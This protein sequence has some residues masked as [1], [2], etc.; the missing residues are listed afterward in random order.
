MR[1]HFLSITMLLLSA[2]PLYAQKTLPLLEDANAWNL[3]ET[4]PNIISITDGELTVKRR[5]YQSA[6]IM[7]TAEHENFRLEFDF[8]VHRWCELILALHAPWN[9]AWPAGLEVVLSDHAGRA[10]SPFGAGALLGNVAPTSVPVRRNDQWNHCEITLDWPTF[11]LTINGEVVQDLDLSADE[12]LRYKLRKGR[13][14]FRD[15][16][17]WGFNVRNMNLTPLPDTQG[18]LTLFDGTS[19]EGWKEVRPGDATWSLK[20]GI[21]IGDNG[22]GY[23]QHERAVQDFDLQL[24]YRSTPTANGGV[25]FRWM[26]DDSDR[27][28]EIQI[29]DVP[30][31]T[32]PSASIYSISRARGDAQF[33]VG[34]WQLLQ[35]SVR[36][37]FAVTHLNGVQTAIT[38]RLTKIRSGHI[39]LQMHKEKSTIE[40]RDISLVP[41]D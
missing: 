4:D 23:L 29:L 41:T 1:P 10:P 28:N 2:T 7:T 6:T 21:I 38:D 36:G 30:Q 14:G 15:L 20:D 31:C 25:F 11:T 5:T 33:P 3:V 12:R 37:A 18:E 17:G 8:L 24:Y 26:T 39:T 27:G 16:L 35:L 13:I 40:F 9:S 22:N 34:S 32:M 19:L